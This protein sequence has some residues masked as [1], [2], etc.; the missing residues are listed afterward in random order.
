ML[1][2]SKV[3]AASMLLAAGVTSVQ[4]D[5]M[6]KGYGKSAGPASYGCDAS[7]FGGG[8]VGIHGATGSLTSTLTDREFVSWGGSTERTEDGYA[9]GAQIGYNWAK[10]STVF[11]IEADISWADFDS[12]ETIS[13]VTINREMDWLSSIRTKSGLAIN[14]LFIYVTGGVAFAN[15]N[16]RTDDVVLFDR[17][18]R[19]D[20]TRFGWV[21][22]VGTEYAWSDRVRITG[23]ILYYDLGTEHANGRAFFDTIPFRF[24]D[25]N[26]LWVSR[27]GLNFSLGD[28][29]AAYEP[30]K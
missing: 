3:L 4:A 29:S 21:A 27:I 19:I 30:M 16:T 9:F 12:R 7:K 20:E 18:T 6:S 11:G 23:D 8:F 15:M 2:M 28:R 17:T 10:S 24:D 22:G 26:S 5:G 13:G 14:D 25:H 1:K